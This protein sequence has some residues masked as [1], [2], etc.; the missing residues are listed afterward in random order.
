MKGNLEKCIRNKTFVG[1]KEKMFYVWKS[2]HNYRG[3]NVKKTNKI[4]TA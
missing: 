1:T 3:S 2:L 4:I